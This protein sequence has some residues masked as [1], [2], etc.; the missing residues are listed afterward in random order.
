MRNVEEESHVVKI[1]QLKTHIVLML[2]GGEGGI[3]L[4]TLRHIAG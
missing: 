4:C 2:M 1:S 3:P